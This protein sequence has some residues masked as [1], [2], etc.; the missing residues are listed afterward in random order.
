MGMF[1]SWFLM[2]SDASL[3]PEDD[4]VVGL[5]LFSRQK[6]ELTSKYCKIVAFWVLIPYS[7]FL[8]VSVCVCSYNF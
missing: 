3:Q 5:H 7:K 1:V 2:S 8:I 4:A 6:L